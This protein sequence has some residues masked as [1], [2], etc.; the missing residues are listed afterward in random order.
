MDI[1]WGAGGEG[2]GSLLSIHRMRMYPES[3]T[4]VL[5]HLGKSIVA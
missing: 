3:R 1:G 5:I 2:E 4:E